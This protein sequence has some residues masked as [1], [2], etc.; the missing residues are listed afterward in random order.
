VGKIPGYAGYVHAIKPENL[1]GNTFGKTTLDVNANHFIKGQD[2]EA[3][4]KYTSSHTT[5]FIPPSERLQRTAAD[6]VGVPNTKIVVK[7]VP[8]V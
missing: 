5:N 7:E 1:Y 2:F 6:I 4:N 3:K 8:S